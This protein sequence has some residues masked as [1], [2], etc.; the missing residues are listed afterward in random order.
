MK[1]YK[2][3]PAGLA[4]APASYLKSDQ[5]WI[6]DEKTPEE[7]AQTGMIWLSRGIRHAG[8]LQVQTAFCTPEEIESDFQPHSYEP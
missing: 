6:M 1:E 7:A 3:T 2:L 8:G 4:K 5:P